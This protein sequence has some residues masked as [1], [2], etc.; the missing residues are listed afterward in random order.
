MFEYFHVDFTIYTPFV[1]FEHPFVPLLLLSRHSVYTYLSGI[2]I[3][4]PPQTLDDMMPG[5]D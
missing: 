5:P 4:I 3:G 2:Y 1:C